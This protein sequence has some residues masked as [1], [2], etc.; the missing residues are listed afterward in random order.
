MLNRLRFDCESFAWLLSLDVHTIIEQYVGRRCPRKYLCEPTLTMP[1]DMRFG[2]V[3]INN[4]CWFYH[5]KAIVISP[6]YIEW[7]SGHCGFLDYKFD[8]ILN[9]F[10]HQLY[11]AVACMNEVV[12][13]NSD[14]KVHKRFPLNPGRPWPKQICMTS[15][16]LFLYVYPTC[17]VTTDERWNILYKRK[18]DCWD[19]KVFPNNMIAV[20]CHYRR[21]EVFNSDW[22]M[23]YQYPCT[24]N[25]TISDDN[26]LYTIW[27]DKNEIIINNTAEMRE[28]K[29]HWRG[30]IMG[31][32]IDYTGAFILVFSDSILRI[33]TK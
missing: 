14:Y 3:D 12:L 13:F 27:W 19:L 22:K 28:Y 18:I 30:T 15:D 10:R 25:F 4:N 7:T 21:V 23:L 16:G 5:S 1:P 32:D 29:I 20:N 17:I 6:T 2:I 24:G 31:F 8:N 26:N 11:I 9:V 33:P